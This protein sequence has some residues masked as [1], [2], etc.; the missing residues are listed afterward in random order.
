MVSPG[1]DFTFCTK[2]LYNIGDYDEENNFPPEEQDLEQQ[3]AGTD[4]FLKRFFSENERTC[5]F[6]Q[7]VK[8]RRRVG[9][10]FLVL[11]KPIF[12]WTRLLP[13]LRR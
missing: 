10:V 9:R 4:N 5:I 3:N 6:S 1:A 2:F 7:V 11:M 12:C 13:V 8:R